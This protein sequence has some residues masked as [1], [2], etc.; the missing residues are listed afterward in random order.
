MPIQ[1]ENFLLTGD[2]GM[3]TKVDVRDWKNNGDIL[4]ALHFA[5]FICT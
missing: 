3:L 1:V 5:S 4:P 2:M